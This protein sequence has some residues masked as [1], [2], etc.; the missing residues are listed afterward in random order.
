MVETGQR[1]P[2]HAFLIVDRTERAAHVGVAQ[3]QP[4]LDEAVEAGLDVLRRGQG[5]DLVVE[6]E[7]ETNS[8]RRGSSKM[9]KCS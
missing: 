3:A 4:A 2:L 8:S 9:M 6:G 5:V 1:R 7:L